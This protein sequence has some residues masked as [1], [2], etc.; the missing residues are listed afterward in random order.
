MSLKNSKITVMGIQGSGKTE[1]AKYLASQFTSPVWYLVH[2]DDMIRM[3]RNLRIIKSEE[4]DEEELNRMC[5]KII[6][7]GIKGKTD[8]FIIDETDMFINRHKPLSKYLND[9]VINHRHYGLT[10]IF[11]TR[12]PQDIPAKIVESCEHL[13]IFALP[14]STN[15]DV[16]LN[17]IDKNLLMMM[18]YLSK[19]K[20][21]FIYKRLG[22]KPMISKPIPLQDV[23][24]INRENELIPIDS[25]V[26][27]SGNNKEIFDV[28]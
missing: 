24:L 23:L 11:V 7:Q 28:S 12:R 2:L 4:K 9:L 17:A 14:N 22:H 27:S 3:P 18:N 20:H 8:C 10:V 16:K 25:F 1:L 21:N 19:D 26:D 5:R 6:E 13:F 15:V